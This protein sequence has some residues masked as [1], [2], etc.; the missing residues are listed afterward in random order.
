[1]N[2]KEFINKYDFKFKKK[3]GQNFIID[4]NILSSIVEKANIEENPLIIEI[5][6]GAGALTRHL[7]KYGNVLGYEI[8]KSLKP[9]LDDIK[10]N[11]SKFNIIYD[12]FLKRNINDDIKNYEY[13]KLY[14]ISNLPYY[15][16]TPII[17]K[18][19]DEKVNIHKIVIMVQ[20]EV[21]E[22]FNAKPCTKEYNSLSIF[23]NY[24][25]DVK[26]MLDVSRNVFIPRPNVDSI[27]LELTKV[28]KK[29]K[30]S[31]ETTF[32]KLIKESFVQKRKTLKNNLKNY[33][34]NI[35]SKV[36]DKY[37]LPHN[38]RAE[39]ISIDIFSDISNIIYASNNQ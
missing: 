39:Q 1:M 19:I 6:C 21:G 34:F 2:Q 25:F 11:D 29:Y 12:D 16:T 9:V 30:V 27:V 8:D 7:L 32:F 37:N 35:V 14:V 4:E 5:G 10:N 33:D 18:L 20:K 23:I 3:F 13:S 31:D 17:N 15:I 38:V 36:L 24:N 28:E 26:K 22:R